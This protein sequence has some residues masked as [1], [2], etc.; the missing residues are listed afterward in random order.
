MAPVAPYPANPLNQVEFNQPPADQLFRAIARD[1]HILKTAR[2][3]DHAKPQP[4]PTVKPGQVQ[5]QVLNGTNVA[6]LALTTANQLTT[7]G[8]KVV[9]AGNATG[10]SSS[11]VI[12]YTSAAQM[13]QVNTLHKEIPS[14]QI[15]K[16]TGLHGS[17]INLVLGSGFKGMGTH[18]AH[19]RRHRGRSTS[20]AALSKNYGGV[21]GSANIC[22]QSAAFTGPDTPTQFGN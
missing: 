6:G 4:V 10:T 20:A 11:T 22:H 21:N 15:K 5:L 8:F 1:N 7:R 18:R 17:T 13:P 14:A 19:H 16:V 3:A 2:R 12:E 9:R